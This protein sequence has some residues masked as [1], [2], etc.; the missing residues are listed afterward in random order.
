MPLSNPTDDKPPVN[1]PADPVPLVVNVG[2]EIVTPGP[3][4]AFDKVMALEVATTIGVASADAANPNKIANDGRR[5]F[6][7]TSNRT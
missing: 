3:P 2:L 4:I 5:R 7:Q 1:V 6:I